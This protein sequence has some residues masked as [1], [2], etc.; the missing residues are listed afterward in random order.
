MTVSEK[1]IND[2][3]GFDLIFMDCNMPVMDGFQATEE[4]RHLHE[5]GVIKSNPVICALTAYTTDTFE[6][7]AFDCGMDFF[8]T[9]PVKIKEID[10][11][12]ESLYNFA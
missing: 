2:H 12:I 11:L 3:Q 7:K 4:I 8:M 6:T 10:K 9:K 5:R 1:D